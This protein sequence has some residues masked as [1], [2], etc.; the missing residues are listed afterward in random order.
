MVA[1]MKWILTTR[2]YA[3]KF[4]P[5]RKPSRFLWRQ[6]LKRTRKNG[7]VLRPP[8]PV[9][10]GHGSDGATRSEGSLM[11]LPCTLCR[12]P[13]QAAAMCS[14]LRSGLVQPYVE[15]HMRLSWAPPSRRRPRTASATTGQARRSELPGSDLRYPDRGRRPRR[16]PAH[17]SRPNRDR[18]SSTQASP[19]TAGLF[20]CTEHDRQLGGGSPLSRSS[21][22][23]GGSAIQARAPSPIAAIRRAAPRFRPETPE[24]GLQRWQLFLNPVSGSGALFGA[25]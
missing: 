16:P 5:V 17:W 23:A 7:D 20:F 1:D 3:S 9:Q 22:M 13:I 25:P 21:L 18:A 15:L 14:L 12:F 8:P 2:R 10:R 24:P 4:M 6:I 11:P 19:E